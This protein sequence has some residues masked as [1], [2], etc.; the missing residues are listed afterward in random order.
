MTDPEAAESGADRPADE[1]SPAPLA[2]DVRSFQGRDLPGHTDSIGAALAATVGGPVGRH[3]LIGRTRFLTPLRVMM[4]IAL[5]FLALGYSTKAACLQT[6]GT[7]TAEQRVANWEN[8]RAYYQLCYSDTV[9]LY[10]AEL[11]N[12]GKFPYKS[13][14]IESDSEGTPHITYGSPYVMPVRFNDGIGVNFNLSNRCPNRCSYCN[15]PKHVYDLPIEAHLE[16]INRLAP[17]ERIAILQANDNHPFEKCNRKRTFRLLD[18]F[19]RRE[20]R[21]PRLLN[22]FID[23]STLLENGRD[24]IWRFFEQLRDEEH[25]FQFG[26]ECTDAEVALALGRRY[27][28]RPRD[29]ERLDAE[30]GAIER[31]ARLLPRSRF[32]VFYILTPFESEQ[33]IASTAS[34]ALAFMQLGN[35]YTG[36]N[37]LWPLPGSPNRVIYRNQYFSFEDMPAD[38]TRRLELIT[39]SGLNFW[40]PALPAGDLLDYLMGTEVKMYAEPGLTSNTLYHLT[41]MRVLAS[42]AFRTYK[43]GRTM[44]AL[45]EGLPDDLQRERPDGDGDLATSLLELG[46]CIDDENLHDCSVRGK[47]RLAELVRKRFWLWGKAKLQRLVWELEC[48]FEFRGRHLGA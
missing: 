43:P 26:R 15:S 10:T 7:G 4:L 23:P 28:G 9:P 41:M 22:F 30:R 13:S 36:S 16:E 18:A 3:A 35:I 37:L 19:R 33:S 40:H 1:V 31:L 34:E 20:K 47:I 27:H 17:A 11:L 6:T 12:L 14:W 48:I 38:L 25:Q 21:Q 44:S 24:E 45:V 8:N 39:P 5:V 29:G 46:K 2:R 42:I 32:K